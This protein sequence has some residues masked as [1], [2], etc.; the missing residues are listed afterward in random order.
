[1]IKSWQQKLEM[2]IKTYL[3]GQSACH[4]FYHLDRVRDNAMTI[5]KEIDCDKEILEAAALLHDIG[6]KGHEGDDKNHHLYGMEVAKKWLP[7]VGFPN[8]KIPEVIE[9]IR[10][11]DNFAWGHNG[12]KTDHIVTKIIQDAD[13]IDA[14]GAIGI[15]RITYYHGEVGLPIYSDEELPDEKIVWADHSLLDQIRREPMKKWQYL[16]FPISKKISKKRS[17][18]V[19]VFYNELKQELESYHKK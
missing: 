3:T 13:R 10:L 2:K 18:F 4:D 17:E 6:Y 5:E 1:M 19:E 16:N 11:H 7:E 12:E 14:L 9:A 15:A 8:K